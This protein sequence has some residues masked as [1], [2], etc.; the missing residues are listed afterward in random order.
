MSES[1]TVNSSGAL[2]HPH[3]FNYQYQRLMIGVSAFLLPV[4]VMIVGCDDLPSISASYH[5]HA[6]DIFVGCLVA[7]GALMIPYQGEKG[8]NTSEYWA[9]KVGGFSAS[10]VALVPTACP[11]DSEEAY[12]C[13]LNFE[14]SRANETVHLTFA[15]IVFI[16]LFVLCVVFRNRAKKK[17]TGNSQK[18]AHIYLACM[19][20]IVVGFILIALYKFN[21]K[22]LG[23]TTFFWAEAIMLFSFSL[24]WLTASKLIFL[25][26]GERR[27]ILPK[28]PI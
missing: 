11:T 17:H 5:T 16:S 7:V 15:A 27:K 25:W 1:T 2:D 4:L 9:A 3:A 6:R 22:L 24:A 10:V 12:K 21:I 19:I 23:D 20:G 18:R 28:G 14:C 26:D 8:E 13:F